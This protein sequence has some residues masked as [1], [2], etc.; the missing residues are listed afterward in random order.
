[1]QGAEHKP[2]FGPYSRSAIFFGLGRALPGGEFH[3]RRHHLR[4]NAGGGQLRLFR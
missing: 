4:V 3:C 1:M 2:V